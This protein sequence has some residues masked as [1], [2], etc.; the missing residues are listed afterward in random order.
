MPSRRYKLKREY[1]FCFFHK[2]EKEEK[3][4]EKEE[5]KEEKKEKNEEK[6]RAERIWELKAWQMTCKMK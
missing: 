6:C 3:K 1:F 4:E 5:E 2:E